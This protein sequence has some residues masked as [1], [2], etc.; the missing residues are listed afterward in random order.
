MCGSSNFAPFDIVA[1]A[2]E[3]ITIA[4]G[5]YQRPLAA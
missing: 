4:A 1:G 5:E 3:S 2:F